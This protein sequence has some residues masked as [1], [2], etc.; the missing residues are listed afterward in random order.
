MIPLSLALL[1]RLP[2]LRTYIMGCRRSELP[3]YRSPASDQLRD[4]YEY[5]FCGQ[6]AAG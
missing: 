5:E 6:L 2:N 1:A 4:V 3:Q